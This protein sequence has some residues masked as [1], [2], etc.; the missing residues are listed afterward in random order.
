MPQNL[1]RSYAPLQCSRHPESDILK[2]GTR[3]VGELDHANYKMCLEPILEMRH[4][5]QGGP[6]V[7]VSRIL[8]A[9]SKK[10][11]Q[12][13]LAAYFVFSPSSPRSFNIGFKPY[14]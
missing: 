10:K 1:T 6:G 11:I 4:I 3:K 14:Y 2:L 5:S 9:T 8:Y 13:R 12:V 7:L